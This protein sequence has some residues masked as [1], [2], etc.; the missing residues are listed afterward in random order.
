MELGRIVEI[1]FRVL[2]TREI[3]T[4]ETPRVTAE[5][6]LDLDLE[7]LASTLNFRLA[8]VSPAVTQPHKRPVD[9]FTEAPFYLQVQTHTPVS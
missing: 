9:C 8:H 1:C 6:L 3:G 4:A 2:L 7:D 5:K